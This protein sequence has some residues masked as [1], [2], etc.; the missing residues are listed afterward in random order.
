MADRLLT[1]GHAR[2]LHL[3]SSFDS[4]DLYDKSTRVLGRAYD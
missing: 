3:F 2:R 1:D 4:T